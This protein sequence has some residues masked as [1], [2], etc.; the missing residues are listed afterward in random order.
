MSGIAEE[1]HLVLCESRRTP[2]RV[3]VEDADGNWLFC[4][5]GSVARPL[6]A[7]IVRACNAHDDLVRAVEAQHDAIDLLFAMLIRLTGKYESQGEAL[8]YP[9]Q[10]GRPWEACVLGHKAL[11]KLK[12]GS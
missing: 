7:R 11:A 12:G 1:I 4:I 6:G 9:S 8:F 10:S 3:V 2:G 5:D